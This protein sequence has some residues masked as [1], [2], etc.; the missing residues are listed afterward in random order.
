VTADPLTP[1]DVRILELEGPL[2][3][4]HTCK[5]IELAGDAPPLDELRAH[6]AA[7]LEAVPRLR[8]RLDV[9]GPPG[10]VDD[11]AFDIERHVL[12]A[13]PVERLE[14]FVAELM[15]GRLDRDRPLWTLH[16]VDGAGGRP[17]LVW[18]IHHALADGTTAMRFASAVLWE[19]AAR[20]PS[21]G[22][23]VRHPSSGPRS[24]RSL[25]KRPS[26]GHRAASPH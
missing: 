20:H 17:A 15:A 12:D 8:R 7:R 6:V 21:S 14:A 2:V 5:V 4:G 23:A 11:E 26:E 24:L 18:R 25:A 10:W 9:S 19:E 13:P 1:E 22:R 16:R 3:A